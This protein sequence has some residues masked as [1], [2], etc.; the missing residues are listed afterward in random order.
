[1]KI[2]S[3]PKFLTLLVDTVVSLVLY[4]SGKY[5]AP[6]ALEDIKIVILAIQPIVAVL[7]TNQWRKENIRIDIGDVPRHLR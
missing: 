3:D 1:M 4:F 5:A 2:F 7:I 6:S